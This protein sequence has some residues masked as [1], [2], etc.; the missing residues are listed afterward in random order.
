[1]DPQQPEPEPGDGM[2]AEI[3]GERGEPLA[4][5]GQEQRTEN[6]P[7]YCVP[8]CYQFQGRIS[9]SIVPCTGV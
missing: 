8:R 6:S 5:A 4:L 2:R 9:A 1:M 3:E 7:A